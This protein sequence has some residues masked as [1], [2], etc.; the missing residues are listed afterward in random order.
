MAM[1]GK[2]GRLAKGIYSATVVLLVGLILVVGNFVASRVLAR[3]DLTHGREFTISKATREVLR[4]LDD[5]VTI[6]VYFSKKLPP[7]L[8]TLRR[9]IDD[10]LRG[11]QAYSHGKVRVEYIDPSEKPEEEQKLRYLG[12]PQIQLNVLEKDQ[13]QVI[14]GYMGLAILYAD[15]HQSIPVVQDVNTLE[16]DLTA[17]IL[18]VLSKE[19]RIVGYLTGNGA[20]DL[21]KDYESLGR[22]LSQTY[23]V[24][25]VD[26]A[27]GRNPVG[28][29]INTLIVARP[30]SVPTR[31]QWQIDQYL[32]R[33][34]RVLFMVDPIKLSE[35]MGLTNP[36]PVASGIDDQ[37]AAY[38]VK[39]QRALVED[40]VNENA[41]FTQGYM[42][43]STPYP[44][45]PKVSGKGLSDK[46]PI[47]SRL[48][49]LVLPWCAPLEVVASTGD[50][51]GGGSQSGVKATVLARSST[52][53]W[54][55]KGRYDLTPP[56]PFQ[57]QQRPPDKGESYP[58]A[59]A[60]VGRF[61]SFF[62][63]K[64][65][66]AAPGDSTSTAPTTPDKMVEESPETQVIVVGNSQFANSNFISMFPGNQ[67]FILN[68]IDWMTLGDKLIAIRSR[69]TAER[70]LKISSA[71]GKALFKYANTFGVAILVAA[72]GI[73]Q[74]MRRRARR[75]A[76]MVHT[77]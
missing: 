12:I 23:D 71:T 34:G 36:M 48:D 24:Q 38:G 51:T 15:R 6:K 43:Y 22:L 58:L 70:P 64:P 18:Q 73:T 55:Q 30:E 45:W 76:A 19:K 40:R 14:N 41:G 13:L 74:V 44:F 75:S 2:Q 46:N 25:P 11:Y 66:P 10:V 54:L 4:G 47:T 60:L 68:A 56:S 16:Y 72:F 50:T 1:I 26:L 63:G 3:I 42:R 29:Q 69:G 5:V 31:V 8:A 35:E 27:Q 7:N 77:A 57:M 21:N 67:N 17:G 62:S 28:N 39:V 61:H 37:L 53:A 59:V 33:G 65:I 49:A 32:M 20:P 52:G 9:N